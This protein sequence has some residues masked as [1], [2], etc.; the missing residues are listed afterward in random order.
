MHIE[1]ISLP[2]H[3]FKCACGWALLEKNSNLDNEYRVS[4]QLLS[5]KN[6]MLSEEQVA[7]MAELLR[8]ITLFIAQEKQKP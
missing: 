3:I 7:Q 5:A 6:S 4:I 8:E 1:R 2:K